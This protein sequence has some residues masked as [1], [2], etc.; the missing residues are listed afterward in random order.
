MAAG[1]GVQQYGSSGSALRRTENPGRADQ[2][3]AGAR[4]PEHRRELEHRR[5]QLH[6]QR[7]LAHADLVLLVDRDGGPEMA[8]HAGKPLALPGIARSRSDNRCGTGGTAAP[9]SP[10]VAAAAPAAR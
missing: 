10:A 3:V 2:D 6:P 4:L 7:L 9:A 8:P 5:L 1:R